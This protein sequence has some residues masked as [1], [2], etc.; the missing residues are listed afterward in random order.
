MSQHDYVID[1][2]SGA[3]VRAD[4][5]SA[6]SAIQSLNSGTSAPS[7]TAAGMLW[8]DTTGGAPYALKV[9]DAGN[10][11]W[12]TLASVTDPGADGNIETSATIKGTID[13]SATFPTG[14][15]LQVLQTI[16]TDKE[17]ISGSQT[18]DDFQFVPAQGGSG[19]LQQQI[20]TTGSNKVL[21][22]FNLN[23]SHEVTGYTFQGAIFRGT[24]TD[25]AVASCTKLGIGT[26]AL[27]SQNSASYIGQNPGGNTQVNGSV[28]FLDSPGAGTHFYKV[29]A[30]Y[31]YH[32]STNYG[33]VNRSK[34]DGNS[35]YIASTMSQITLME[36]KA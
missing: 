11:H 10:N 6:L 34:S 33:Y 7:S 32:G 17:Q 16:K 14:H 22:Y 36:I 15:V 18:Q 29:G 9:R 8:L 27:S 24:A 31:E 26:E 4:I 13:S 12:L 23:Q 35:V 30:F 28:M 1:N 25:T 19:V 3:T 21:V 2:A 20:T 5:N